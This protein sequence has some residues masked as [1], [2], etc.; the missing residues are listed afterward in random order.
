MVEHDRDVI[1]NS[2][3]LIEMGPGSGHLGGEVMFAGEIGDFYK[4]S[5][6]ITL[7]YLNGK[8]R[9]SKIQP[10]SVDLKTF[11]HTIQLKGCKGHNLK[12]IDVSFPMNRLVTVTGVSGSGKSTLIS[13]TLYP[14]L[15]RKLGIDFPNVQPYQKIEGYEQ[16][17]DLILIDQ[18][19]VGKTA[20]SNPV[21]YLKAFDLIREVM[22]ST[23]ESKERGYTPGTFSLNVDGGRCPVCKGLGYETID[24]LFMDDVEVPCD[25]CDGK[26]Y[27]D[28]VLE[29]TYQGKNVNEILC[30]TV[31]QAMDFFVH[32]PNIRKP[33][34]LLK[35][36]GLEYLTLGQS[37]SSLSGGESQRLKIAR[38][39]LRTQ[40]KNTLY[41]MDEPTTGLHFRE[42]ELLMSVLNQLVEAGGSVILVEHN[43]EVIARS[44]YVIDIGPEAGDQGGEIVAQGSPL[45]IAQSAHSKTGH[46]LQEY[47]KGK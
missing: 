40:Q 45:D 21:T 19:A 22:S 15:A 33:L 6:S 47:L 38:E 1:E 32:Y 36:V 41:I 25:A 26:R 12:N 13:K 11:K 34:S 28:E 42:I 35:A 4:S 24:M 29:I 5:D 31:D 2:T 30:M 23:T 43:L 10:R 16:I 20:R 9:V 18:S 3:H 46:Y 37:A 14:A 17:K 27:R 39:L 8:K 44:D 7:P